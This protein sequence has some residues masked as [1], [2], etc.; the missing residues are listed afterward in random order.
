MLTDQH[1]QTLRSINSIEALLEFVRRELS[2]P[3]EDEAIENVTYE[4]QPEELGLK[5]EHFPKI[6]SIRQLRPPSTDQPWGIFF[7][8]FENKKIP[9]TV[10]RRILNHLAVKRRADRMTVAGQAWNPADLMFL[11]TYGEEYEGMREVAM[12]H[13]HETP[14][15]LPSLRVLDWHAGDTPTKLKQTYETLKSNLAWPENTAD[16]DGWRGKWSSPFK[17]KPGH[18]ISTAKGLADAMA[19]LS[20]KIR[21]ACNELLESETEKGP[22]TK[23]YKAFKEAL[24]HDLKP[25]D[26]AD[27]FA[28]T[29][30][31]G[32]LTAAISRTDHG[33]GKKGTAL[34]TE[35]VATLVPITNPFLKEIL[36]TFLDVG[37]RKKAGMDF[38]ELGV[39]DVV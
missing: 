39:Q 12:A 31:Y 13:F 3:I 10:M 2:W 1:V 30:T 35:D 22:L 4:F 37:G 28:Q 33:Q 38:D 19:V 18:V 6:N 23:L 9:V 32:L 15:D 25:D 24:I 16:A 14:G 17:H 27:T 11:T 7:I 34:L 20:Q 36:E 21:R 29:I 26:F 8:D 5:P